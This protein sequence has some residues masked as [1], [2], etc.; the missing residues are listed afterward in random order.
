MNLKTVTG[1]LQSEAQGKNRWK[2]NKQMETTELGDNFRW[3]NNH[4]IGVYEGEEKCSVWKKGNK[5]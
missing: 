4:T 3:P 5:K 1:T 2:T